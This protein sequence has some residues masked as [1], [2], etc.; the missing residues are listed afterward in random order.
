MNVNYKKHDEILRNEVFQTTKKWP[1]FNLLLDNLINLSKSKKK[2]DVASLE[3][4][5]LYGGISLFAPYFYKHNFTS[6]DCSPKSAKI[7]G[8]YNINLVNNHDLIKIKTNFNVSLNKLKNHNKKYDLIIIPN[9]VHHI[10]DQTLLFNIANKLL[11]RN[12]SLYVFEALLREYHQIPDDFIR[13]TPAGLKNVINKNTNLK[14]Y[15]IQLTGNVFSAI[16]YCWLQALEYFPLKK[17]KIM[18][19]WFYKEQFELLNEYEKKYTKNLF[20]VNSSFPTAFS[21]YAKKE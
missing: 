13:Y 12:G 10:K 21:I 16:Q 18:E 11:K 9:L 6:F 15:D 7:N 19:N 20:R 14:V 17:R 5:M 4:G 8:A 3:R 1:Q 2:L